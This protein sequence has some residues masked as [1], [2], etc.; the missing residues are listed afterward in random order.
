MVHKLDFF[1]GYLGPMLHI[2][3]HTNDV[4]FRVSGAGQSNQL[5]EGNL[6]L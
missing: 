2:G 3:F 5:F 1:S 6:S 4:T